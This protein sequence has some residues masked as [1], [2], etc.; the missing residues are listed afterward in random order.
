MT[1]VAALM[2]FQAALAAPDLLDERAADA[3]QTTLWSRNVMLVRHYRGGRECGWE[4]LGESSQGTGPV[5]ISPDVGMFDVGDRRRVAVVLD[6]G[7]TSP[8]RTIPAAFMRSWRGA[9]LEASAF[10]SLVVTRLSVACPPDALDRSTWEARF[11]AARKWE[12]RV[13]VTY[14]LQYFSVTLS[15][16]QWVQVNPVLVGM[17]CVRRGRRCGELLDAAYGAE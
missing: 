17:P 13:W 8:N 3:Y 10:S 9:A 16:A 1:L 6:F 2:C 14:W 7:T 11:K 5:Q 4:S 12:R 15:P